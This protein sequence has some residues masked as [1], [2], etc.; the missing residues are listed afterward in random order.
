MPPAP[1]Q[2]VLH[3][4]TFNNGGANHPDNYHGYGCHSIN[5]LLSDEHDEVQCAWA[6]YIE[7]K[8]AW[9]KF[10]PQLRFA[11][12]NAIKDNSTSVRY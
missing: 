5:A 10:T 11:K 2:E 7:G 3:I 6:I 8:I 1:G 9:Q 4:I 12:H